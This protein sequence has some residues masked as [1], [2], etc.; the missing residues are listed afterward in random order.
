V[1]PVP[2]AE[3]GNRL[4]LNRATFEQLRDIGFSVTQATRVITYRDRQEGFESVDDL[5]HV[6]G[7]PGEFL[8]DVE[9]KLTV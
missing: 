5:A 9:E 8:R 3:A 1:A 4:N 6:P 7:M 2:A